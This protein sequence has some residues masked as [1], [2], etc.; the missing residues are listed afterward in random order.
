MKQEEYD[1]ISK[2]FKSAAGMM[3]EDWGEMRR[4][5]FKYDINYTNFHSAIRAE[6]R[7]VQFSWIIDFCSEYKFSINWIFY[8]KGKTMID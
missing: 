8:G 3:F 1:N 2:R 4:F 6:I 7:R 5:C